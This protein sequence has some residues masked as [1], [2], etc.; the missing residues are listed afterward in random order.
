[1][2]WI[3]KNLKSLYEYFVLYGGLLFFVGMLIMAYNVFRT[4]VE[5][6]TFEATIPAPAHA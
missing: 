3:W 6:K 2:K 5:G 1:M 4:V